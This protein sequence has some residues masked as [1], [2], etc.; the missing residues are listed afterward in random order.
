M[1]IK[2]ERLAE[3]ERKFSGGFDLAPPPTPSPIDSVSAPRLVFDGH[4]FQPRG[5]CRNFAHDYG[6]RYEKAL[7]RFDSNDEITI[8]EMGVLRGVGLAIWCELFP[9]ARVIGLDVDTAHFKANADVLV[10]RGAFANGLPELYQYDELSD[11]ARDVL[12]DILRGSAID[13]FIDDALHYTRAIVKAY[14]DVLPFMHPSGVYIVEDNSH[15]ATA[16]NNYVGRKIATQHAELAI[17][18]F[19][20]LNGGHN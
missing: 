18:D 14:T 15:T 7:E 1:R 16:I 13:V 5:T 11:S 20:R 8:V 19:Y 6:Q 3:L 2:A 12:H 10:E 17:V 9:K 4:R